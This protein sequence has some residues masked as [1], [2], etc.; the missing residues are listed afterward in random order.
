MVTFL[1]SVKLHRVGH[2]LFV[3]NVFENKE[4]RLVLVVEIVTLRLVSSIE[5]T[6]R[7]SVGSTHR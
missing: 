7:A 1:V 6:V 3:R 2:E 4:V 5:E